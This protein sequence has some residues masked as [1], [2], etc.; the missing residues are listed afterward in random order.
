MLVAVAMVAVA[1]T[2]VR[3]SVPEDRTFMALIPL[4]GFALLGVWAA[5]LRRWNIIGEEWPVGSSG[6]SRM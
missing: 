5:R 6:R 2:S 1:L 3:M 4:I